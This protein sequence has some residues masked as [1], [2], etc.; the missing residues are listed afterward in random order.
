MSKKIWIS[1]VAAAVV[2]G[3][4][5]APEAPRT[6][7]WLGTVA[8]VG[9]P[10]A[11][12]SDAAP[13][14]TDDIRFS[15]V[16]EYSTGFDDP[17]RD[18]EFRMTLWIRDIDTDT[19]SG[20]DIGFM[21]DEGWPCRILVAGAG[22]RTHNQFREHIHADGFSLPTLGECSLAGRVL[23]DDEND[24]W[25]HADLRC[26]AEANRVYSVRFNRYRMD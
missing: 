2:V 20:C 24:L 23:M 22:L 6:E 7:E 1:T 11:P 13:A 4:C 9:D 15:A 18:K 14:N 12:L 25:W 5:T 17:Y 21:P 3:S 16:L 26:G 10:L 19:D 8:T